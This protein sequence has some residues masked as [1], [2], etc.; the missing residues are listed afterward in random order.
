MLIADLW[1]RAEE[2]R[3]V[4]RRA[5]GLP[6]PTEEELLAGDASIYGVSFVDGQTGRR[7][8]PHEISVPEARVL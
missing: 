5:F 7:I 8:P 1:K 3:L 6:A 2:L 4:A